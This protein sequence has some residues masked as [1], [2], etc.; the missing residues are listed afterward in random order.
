MWRVARSAA[1]REHG[2]DAVGEEGTSGAG[3]DG[4]EGDEVFSAWNLRKCSAE[5]LDML[6]NTY[7]D[8]LLPILLPI[9]QQR[10]QVRLRGWLAACGPGM[11]ESGRA[12]EGVPRGPAERGCSL[13]R[14]QE[15]NWSLCSL[16]RSQEPN[17]SLCSLSRSQEPN[18]KARESA[19]LALGAIS[20][21]CHQVRC[22]AVELSEGS[23]TP[24]ST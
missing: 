3:D 11:G 10:L 14:S 20:H 13:S 5:A 15:P 8:D 4:D 6:S 16:S 19:I 18:W 7:G 2:A 23:R 17:W 21:G 1:A 12:R 9:V 24:D 22:G